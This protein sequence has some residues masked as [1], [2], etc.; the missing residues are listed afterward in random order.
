MKTLNTHTDNVE[1]IENRRNPDRALYSMIGFA[2][3]LVTVFLALVTVFT[4]VLIG[5]RVSGN[6]M[7]P[8]LRNSDYLFV[9]TWDSPDYGDIVVFDMNRDPEVRLDAIKRVV[10]LPGDTIYSVN[11]VLYRAHEGEEAEPVEEP[12]IID[13]W[14]GN[15]Q[16]VTVPED[17]IYVLGDNRLDSTDSRAIGPVPKSA[18]LGVVTGWSVALRDVISPIANFLH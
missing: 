1:I 9:F 4:S 5:V 17:C 12:Y 3:V 14:K 10:G 15:I 7:N 6:S 2:L 11:G 16:P 8:T 13:G 18:V